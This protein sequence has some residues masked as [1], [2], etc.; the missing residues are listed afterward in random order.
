M[1]WLNSI[2]AIPFPG[3]LAYTVYQPLVNENASALYPG[4]TL[5]IVPGLAA[6]FTISPDGTVYTFNLRQGIKFSSGNPLNAYQVWGQMYGL[7]YLSGNSSNWWLDYPVYDMSTSHFG[8]STLALMAKSGLANPSPQLLTI[9]QDTSWPIYV[10]GPNQ[11]VYHLHAPFQF[12]L[13]TFIAFQGLIFDTQWV[14]DHGGFGT[15][16]QFNTLFNLRPIPGTGPYVVTAASEN[17]YAKFAQD[18]NYW[19]RSLTAAQIKANPYL[20][21]GHVKNV[22]VNVKSADIARYTDLS[23]GA[24]QVSSILA[25][26]WPL[27]ANN[28]GRFGY[29]TVPAA[30]SLVVGIS[31]NTH[32]YPTNI[33]AVRQAIVHAINY[34]DISAKVY[35]GTLVPWNGPEYPAWS[36]YYNLGKGPVWPYDPTLAKQILANA[37]IDPTKLPPLEFRVL[38]GCSFCIDTAQIVQAD[39]GAIGLNVNVEVTPSSSYAQPLVSGLGAYSSAL[40]TADQGS[41]LNWLGAFTFAPGAD[42]P[43]DS[44][45][46]W[47]NGV[48]PANNYAIYANP[49]VQACVTAWT[50]TSDISQI[51]S[52][53]TAAQQQI[54]AD[55]PYIW[56]GSLSLLVGSGSVAY[57]KN[58]ITG[59]Y[60]DPVY[61]G[62]SDTFIF[63]T[64]TFVGGS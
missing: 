58:V 41:H 60:V 61:T 53:C 44:W 1:N 32:R 23:T 3:W 2:F 31:L 36:D 59:G 30:S 5:Q 17:N 55:A 56:V 21:P 8:P 15:P 20:D 11:I 57:D 19:G 46:A 43:A 25:E 45:L 51:K 28:P 18:P 7:Y 47:V 4:G 54:N 39:L 13:G 12:F 16:S 50:S 40:A 38:T 52:L 22:V 35:G 14:L 63:N 48:T 42:T 9:M 27:I 33:T 62:Q 6:N 64:V 26:N 34:T 49:T 37:H 10:T 29:S 24:T